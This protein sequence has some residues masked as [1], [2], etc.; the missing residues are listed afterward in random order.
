MCHTFFK[1]IASNSIII[2]KSTVNK[3]QVSHVFLPTM[4]SR[5]GWW[6]CPSYCFLFSVF[7]SGW[8]TYS[9]VQYN[10]DT[11]IASS[12]MLSCWISNIAAG[13]KTGE[14]L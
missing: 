2:S 4:F 10:S 12:S 1:T 14:G 8:S 11:F 6:I 7:Y 5:G 9:T 3:A 13:Q